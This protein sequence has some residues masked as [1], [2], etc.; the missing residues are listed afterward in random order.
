MCLPILQ[1]AR[2]DRQECWCAVLEGGLGGGVGWTQSS[3]KA[4][5]RGQHGVKGDK[6]LENLQ[7]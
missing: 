3:I 2:A 1:R 7:S 4:E 5:T 6:T